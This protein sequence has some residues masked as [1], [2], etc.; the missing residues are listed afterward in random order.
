MKTK[1]IV[2]ITVF[3]IL[4]FSIGSANAQSMRFGI[5]TPPTQLWTTL[6]EQF[7]K[8][9]E[10]QTDGELSISVF[11]AG[12]LGNESAML[13]QLQRGTLD[14][15]LITGG[16]LSS[17]VD[18]FNALLAPGLIESSAHGA[19]FLEEGAMPQKLLG[20]LEQKIGVKGLAYG[21]G[22]ATQVMTNFPAKSLADLKGRRVRITPSPASV[23]YNRI[24]DTAPQAIPL[25]NVYDAFSN[26]QV[27][28][29][30]TQLDGMYTLG[31]HNRADTLLMSNHTL[32]PSVVVVSLKTWRKLNE[33]NKAIVASAAKELGSR[34][35]SQQLKRD[36]AAYDGMKNSVTVVDVDP[37]YYVDIEKQWDEIW[38]PRIPFLKQM[39]AEAN[40]FK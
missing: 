15:M 5:I 24:L 20:G 32:A 38:A 25:T 35:L 1:R 9:V 8:E 40:E 30:E 26:K 11:P 3:T 21:M 29:V 23:D 36:Q 39:R 31:L 4:M 2:L 19:R 27:D 22:G 33:E 10:A 7:A 14:F 34:L 13:Q 28:A 18:S 16:E 6:S 37:S 17:H 12:Q